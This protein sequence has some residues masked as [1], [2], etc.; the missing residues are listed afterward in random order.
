MTVN[1][2]N[3]V[4]SEFYSGG[5]DMS[6]DVWV[7]YFEQGYATPAHFGVESVWDSEEAAKACVKS[8]EYRAFGSVVTNDHHYEK[9]TVQSR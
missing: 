7:V 8:H 3:A 2:G 5:P 9:F 1:R 4:A 6:R